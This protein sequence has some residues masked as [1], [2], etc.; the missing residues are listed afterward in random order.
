MTK[1][2]NDGCRASES[3]QRGPGRA[4]VEQ[5]PTAHTAPESGRTCR[6]CGDRADSAEPRAECLSLSLAYASLL[7]RQ[8]V[9]C[10]RPAPYHRA[11]HLSRRLI[12]TFRSS[13]DCSPTRAVAGKTTPTDVDGHPVYGRRARVHSTLQA[14]P[15]RPRPRPAPPPPGAANTGLIVGAAPGAAPG[16]PGAARPTARNI[17]TDSHRT[18]Y[19]PR[20][21]VHATRCVGVEA[22]ARWRRSEDLLT[23]R[24]AA[25]RA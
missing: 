13:A 15:V 17:T 24:Q 6:S 3:V 9:A 14:R 5:G 4:T 2:P 23:N 7:A 21:A 10:S 19:Q 1:P 20:R 18:T 25:A 11:A 8:P 16:V 22:G 12:G